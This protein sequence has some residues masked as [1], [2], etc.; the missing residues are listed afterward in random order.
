[1]GISGAAISINNPDMRGSD[2]KAFI[3]LKRNT[4]KHNQAYLTGNAVH[5]R[6]TYNATALN[7]TE[8]RVCGGGFQANNNTFLDNSSVIHASNGGAISLVCDFTTV[9]SNEASS[10]RVMN[11]PKNKYTAVADPIDFEVFVVSDFFS[12]I[13][14]NYFTGNEVGQKGSAIYTR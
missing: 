10:D 5:V 12:E 9:L 7:T 4:F 6:F 11:F 14:N 1:M 2:P 3:V 13:T 8:A